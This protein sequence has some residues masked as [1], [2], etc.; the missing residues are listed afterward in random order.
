MAQ[1]LETILFQNRLG[2]YG[3]PLSKHLKLLDLIIDRILRADMIKIPSQ[4]RSKTNR[5]Y[6]VY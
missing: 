4:E 1:M 2:M 3:A 6:M 5:M